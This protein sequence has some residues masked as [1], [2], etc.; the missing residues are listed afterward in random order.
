VAFAHRLRNDGHRPGTAVA[1]PLLAPPDRTRA[2]AA[3]DTAMLR[4]RLRGGESGS[5]RIAQVAPV[6][7][8]KEKRIYVG[9]W[10]RRSH[11]PSVTV[12]DPVH[13]GTGAAPRLRW[14]WWF[15]SEAAEVPHD[16]PGIG[17][18]GASTRL[19]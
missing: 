9:I 15:W 4:A 19:S 10:G 13:C 2:R 1:S 17:T 16:Q 8:S 11:A 14:F 18:S 7:V 5:A 12:T 3:G 6:T